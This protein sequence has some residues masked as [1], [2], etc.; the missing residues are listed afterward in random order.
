M[1]RWVRQLHPIERRA[2]SVSRT[3]ARRSSSSNEGERGGQPAHEQQAD[4]RISRSIRSELFMLSPNTERTGGESFARALG[5]AGYDLCW[6]VIE[7]QKP[8]VFSSLR[9]AAGRPCPGSGIGLY[10]PHTRTHE[11]L[12]AP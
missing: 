3:K 11:G 1:G 5:C 7:T 12:Y 4:T 2:P 8:L 6:V 10:Q 9:L